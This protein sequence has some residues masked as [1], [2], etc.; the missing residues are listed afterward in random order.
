MCGN[1]MLYYILDD[2]IY[3]DLDRTCL[4]VSVYIVIVYELHTAITF[5]ILILI[6][7]KKLI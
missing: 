3:L 1:Y 4:C 6:G 5:A 7:S 2:L